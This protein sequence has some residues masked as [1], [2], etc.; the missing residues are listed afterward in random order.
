MIL[1]SLTLILLNNFC[2]TLWFQYI[3]ITRGFWGFGVLGF[4]GFNAE[5]GEVPV[6]AICG[7]VEETNN[8]NLRSRVLIPC[9]RGIPASIRFSHYH[10]GQKNLLDHMLIS[11]ALLPHFHRAQIYN[12]NL[13]DESLP[14]T[15]DTKYPESDHAAFVCELTQPKD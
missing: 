11:Q 6:E 13:H 4:W 3:K 9:S 12:E 15:S 5:P 10:H 8:P 1:L 14:F 7:S 2:D